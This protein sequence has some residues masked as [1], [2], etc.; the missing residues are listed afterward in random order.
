MLRKELAG[1]SHCQDIIACSSSAPSPLGRII[2]KEP[3]EDWAVLP[4]AIGR[5]KLGDEIKSMRR[6]TKPLPPELKL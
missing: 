3:S 2:P 6:T 1:I 4:I 5:S